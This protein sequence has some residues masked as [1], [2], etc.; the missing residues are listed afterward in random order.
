MC[1]TVGGTEH[2]VATLAERANPADV[3]MSVAIL[4]TPGPVAARLQAAGVPVRSLGG[5]LMRAFA[6]LGRVLAR[7]RFDVVN[8][9][10]FKATIVVRFLVRALSPRSQ[11]VC[12]VRSLHPSETDRL[13]SPKGRLVLAMERA[14]AGLVDA[15]DANS[16]GALDLL[17]GLGVPSRKLHYIPNGI[18]VDDWPEARIEPTPTPVFVCVARLVPRKRHLDL[19]EAAEILRESGLRFRMV[20]AGEGP[21]RTEIERRIAALGLRDHV[22]LAGSLGGLALRE[23]LT[24]ARAMCLVSASEGMSNSVMEAMASGLPVIGSRVNGIQEL[25]VEGASGFLVPVGE[26][27]SL[28]AAM[29]TLIDNPGLAR[30]LGAAGRQR[31]QHEFGLDAMVS[32]KQ[33]F[34]RTLVEG[35]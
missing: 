30:R 18:E 33:A 17:A 29:R 11:F 10:G 31:V 34:Y 19:L 3:K 27:H 9:Y 7:E 2:M 12:G 1:D 16:P 14:T 5:G 25:V 35:R 26:P 24:E 6:R 4:D 23:L 32:A 13:H 22:E 15:Y 20:F 21:L 28:A 8:A